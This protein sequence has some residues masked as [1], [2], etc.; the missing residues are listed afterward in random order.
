[1]IKFSQFLSG[2]EENSGQ[3]NLSYLEVRSNLSYLGPQS[4]LLYLGVQPNLS[5]LGVPCETEPTF[6]LLGKFPICHLMCMHN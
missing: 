1:M 5:Y 6:N 3:S 4:N 2:C